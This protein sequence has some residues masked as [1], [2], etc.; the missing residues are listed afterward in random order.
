MHDGIGDKSQELIAEETKRLHKK[1]DALHLQHEEVK[2]SKEQ[3][4]DHARLNQF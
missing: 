2:A 3:L 4:A 1:F